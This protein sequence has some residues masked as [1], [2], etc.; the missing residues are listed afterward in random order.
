MCMNVE[1]PSRVN[2]KRRYLIMLLSHIRIL[3]CDKVRSYSS[4]VVMYRGC[5]Q[6]F[7]GFRRQCSELKKKF[8]M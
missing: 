5:S 4:V 8:Y 2:E 7:L 3:R 6:S 1:V